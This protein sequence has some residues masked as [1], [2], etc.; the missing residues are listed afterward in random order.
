MALDFIDEIIEPP[1]EGERGLDKA[2]QVLQLACTIA[3][4]LKAAQPLR[5][6]CAEGGCE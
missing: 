5:M 2:H 1:H 6:A 3:K 4:A